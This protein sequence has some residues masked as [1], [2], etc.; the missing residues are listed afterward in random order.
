MTTNR[1]SRNTP[2]HTVRGETITCLHFYICS[3]KSLK[4]TRDT[5][6]DAA[7][8]A[9]VMLYVDNL[10]G[11]TESLSSAL[12]TASSNDVRSGFMGAFSFDHVTE[13]LLSTFH[14][15]VGVAGVIAAASLCQATPSAAGC[16]RATA[17]YTAFQSGTVVMPNYDGL[18]ISCAVGGA[19]ASAARSTFNLTVVDSTA[20]EQNYCAHFE[21]GRASCRERV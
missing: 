15:D 2:T 5:C 12:T 6:I 13:P 17:F 21:I 14:T 20:F 1:K 8:T 18:E 9:M 3:A 19:V 4:A 11:G 7:Y 10:S 16:D